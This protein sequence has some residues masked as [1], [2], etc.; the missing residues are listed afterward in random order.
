MDYIKVIHQ[1]LIDEKIDYLL[2]NSTNEFLVEYNDLEYNS[3]YK[4]TG[5]TGSTGEALASLD[6]VFLFVDGRYHIQADLEVGKSKI[7]VVKQK[8]GE[9]FFELLLKKIKKNSTIGIVAEKISQHNFEYLKKLFKEKNIKIKF[10][11]DPII[12]KKVPFKT[13]F[14]KPLIN[15][16][17]RNN[18]AIFTSNQEEITYITGKKDF[19]ENYNSSVKGKIFILKN[20]IKNLGEN[21]ENI[22]TIYLNKKLTSA[23]DYK[24][25]KE[26]YKIKPTNLLQ[27]LKSIKTEKE[28]KDYKYTFKMTDKTLN[29]IRDYILN[30][31]NISEFDIAQKLE[32]EFLQNEAKC[33]S[34][35]S[36]VAKDKNSALAHYKNNSKEEILKNGSLILI[37][38]GAYYE[39]GLATD[40]TR[41]FVKGTPSELQKKIYTYVL[42]AHLKA[43]NTT[44]KTGFQLDKIARKVLKDIEKGFEFS[45]SLGHG[46]GISVHEFPPSLSPNKKN[47]TEIKKNMCFTIEPGLYNEKYF[48]I[49]LENSCYFDGKRIKSFSNM[50][51]EKNLIDFSLLT[52]KELKQL[53]EFKLK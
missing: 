39:S 35:A 36:I 1:F 43:Y 37:D 33:L 9:T 20:D 29:N 27:N 48:G 40:I 14:K 34:F 42:K 28:I 19:S 11:S 21:L 12:N 38:C 51:F 24:I 13:D 25:L 30:T 52:K 5:F 6:N 18:E 16:K 7:T 41:V 31:E 22:D 2:I 50:C 44:P 15:L 17:L 4:L 3:R 26:N 32:A 53:A 45:H 46:I 8:T 23:Y 47:I 10:V 49:R